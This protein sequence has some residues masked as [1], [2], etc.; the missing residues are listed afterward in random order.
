MLY[1]LDSSA[2]INDLNF[3]LRENEKYVMANVCLDELKDF[4]AKSV[5]ETG[6]RQGS[7]FVRDPSKESLLKAAAIAKEKNYFKLS[8]ADLCVVALAMDLKAEGASFSVVTDDFLVQ[9][10]LKL[11]KLPFEPAFQGKI[12]KL[13]VFGK[14][15]AQA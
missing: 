7:L 15:R 10:F 11:L 1:L 4:R 8:K 13:R 5:A 6:M 14:K 3:E 9:N 2:I 12:K